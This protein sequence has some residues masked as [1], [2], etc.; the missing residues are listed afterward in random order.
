MTSNHQVTNS[1]PAKNLDVPGFLLKQEAKSE[2]IFN[3]QK[4]ELDTNNFNI[5]NNRIV[6]MFRVESEESKH[7][8]M[9]NK[10]DQLHYSSQ[11]S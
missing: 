3:D 9:L 8:R 6:D 11:I 4:H 5:N 10:P 1:T 2:N 7:H